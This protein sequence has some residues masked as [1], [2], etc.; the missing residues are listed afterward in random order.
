MQGTIQ[1]YVLYM[2]DD[3]KKEPLKVKQCDT[4]SRWAKI[5][6]KAFNGEYWLIPFD[7]QI[8]LNVRKGDG[9]LATS[10]CTKIDEHTV[11]API[12]DQ[13]TAVTGTQQGELYFLTSDG[14]IKSQT[15]PIA[16]YQ[17][18]M[19]PDRMESSNDFQSL[20]DTLRQVQTSTEAADTAAQYAN[21]QG[22][23]ARDLVLRVDA[24][25]TEMQ[26]ILKSKKNSMENVI[27][28]KGVP[29]Q[30]SGTAD[31]EEA[32]SIFGQ[33][34]VVVLWDDYVQNSNAEYANMVQIIDYLKRM[35]PEMK[36]SGRIS[37]GMD[38][39]SSRLTMEQVKGYIDDWKTAG[40]NGIFLDKAGYDWKVTRE[41]QNEAITYAREN[42]MFLMLST[43]ILSHIFSAKPRTVEGVVYNPDSLP[44]LL[45]SNDYVVLN[46]LFFTAA[47][48]TVE[49]S[50]PYKIAYGYNYYQ[51]AEPE[52]DN[53]TP[54]QKFGT[55]MIL[56]NQIPREIPEDN[57]KLLMTIAFMGASISN[58]QG[59]AFQYD[60]KSYYPWTM[61]EGV[62]SEN[63]VHPVTVEKKVYTDSNG[64]ESEFGYRW[65][66]NIAGINC[67]LVYDIPDPYYSNWVAGMRYIMIDGHIIDNLWINQLGVQAMVNQ[68]FEA[69]EAAAEGRYVYHNA[70]TQKWIDERKS[71][72]V[73]LQRLGHCITFAVMTDIH[74]R[75]VEDGNEGRFNLARDFWM[76][77]DQLPIDYICCCGDLMS[78][79]QEWDGVYEPRTK[80]IRDILVQTGLPWFAIRGNHDFNNDDSGDDG[81]PSS[82][83][84]MRPFT[85][86]TADLY[87]INGADWR[88]SILSGI[89]DKLGIH[90][91]YDNTYPDAGYYYVDD[92]IRKHRMIFV[93]AY[94]PHETDLGRPYLD[95]SPGN[96]WTSSM[97]TQNQLNWLL[98][99]ALDMTG[100]TDWTVS[101]FGH[102]IPYSDS[103]EA[104]KSE[105]HGYDSDNAPLR[106][107]IKAFQTGS[108]ITG[109]KYI[110]LDT[111][112]HNTPIATVNKDF[113]T[114]G[115]IKVTGFF[116]GHIHDDC[117]KQ[118]DGLNLVVSTCTANKQRTAWS[119]DMNPSK[120]P[121]ERNDTNF[122]MS[123]NVVIINKDTRKVNVVK[124]GSKRN[125]AVKTSSDYEFSY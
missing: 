5:T 33:Y 108:Q 106:T 23:A 56:A 73:A 42:E 4:N 24:A 101:F 97:K 118:V 111:N 29:S 121:P 102:K 6:L 21:E 35:K 3:T 89:E 68:V 62:Y 19:D 49:F 1:S 52:Y 113:T 51:T 31:I 55:Q 115:P 79:T 80:K 85:L 117:Y 76:I 50:S 90:V 124:L 8:S 103:G 114:Q 10:T 9:T 58:V 60:N 75:T 94:E 98:N 99:S 32:C 83:P 22:N 112:A 26:E 17:M 43:E 107:I 11:L 15:F 119:K 64:N 92:D 46:N 34:D 39:G 84:N 88:R 54:Y 96:C 36:I 125:N 110:V 30:I 69:V 81:S 109:L 16:V 48:T 25:M 105:F 37:F 61:P 18:V 70:Y 57:K 82:N 78:Y 12:T 53:M 44:C 2:A 14:D 74:V 28:Y 63:A 87:F 122:A 95:T 72:I 91:V 20:R 71:D 47:K 27:F 77:A 7:A 120:L 65:S 66:A 40:A 59:I 123:V 38:S 41:R 116:A 13:M 104:D 45:R 67:E 93:A 86:E 100:K